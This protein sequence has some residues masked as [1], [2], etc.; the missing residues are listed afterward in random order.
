MKKLLFLVSTVLL[1]S[2]CNGDSGSSNPAG[3]SG[4][5]GG[6]GNGSGAGCAFNWSSASSML[7]RGFPKLTDCLTSVSS[8]S[9][10]TVHLIY[11]ATS[12]DYNAN[13][14]KI[15]SFAGVAPSTSD[16]SGVKS[17][18]FDGDTHTII[19]H[20]QDNGYGGKMVQVTVNTK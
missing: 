12:N 17:F 3:S 2:S 10:S 18:T 19:Y 20:Y 15:E 13:V 5:I 7:P 9:S 16:I 6:G 14:S 11:D 4:G 1:L 8:P